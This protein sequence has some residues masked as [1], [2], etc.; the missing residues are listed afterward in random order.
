MSSLLD[1][2]HY[3]IMAFSLA[4][5]NPVEKVSRASYAKPTSSIVTRQSPRLSGLDQLE[6]DAW[7]NAVK[8]ASPA[9]DVL[10]LYAAQIFQTSSGRYYVAPPSFRDEIL[11]L[12]KNDDVVAR[13]MAFASRAL[14][15]QIA[16]RSGVSV[17]PGAVLVAHTAGLAAAVTYSRAL[18]SGPQQRVVEEVHD[19]V[20]MLGRKSTLTLAELEERLC[21]ALDLPSHAPMH[22]RARGEDVAFGGVSDAFHSQVARKT[23]MTASQMQDMPR[24]AEV[25]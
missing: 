18:M 11:A 3:L 16:A 8:I 9:S 15:E 19:L 25:R 7:L 10:A 20:P 22:V 13:V 23:S 12:K 5:P 1:V 17:S 6:D 2:P 21:S 24:V 4:F 14:K